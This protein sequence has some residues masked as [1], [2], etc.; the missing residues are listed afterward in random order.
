MRNMSFGKHQSFGAVEAN[1]LKWAKTNS[2]NQV[3]SVEFQLEKAKAQLT[4]PHKNVPF[5]F[6][7]AGAFLRGIT[8]AEGANWRQ[9]LVDFIDQYRLAFVG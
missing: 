3:E 5:T 4:G 6:Q 2:I 7:S 8:H 1:A 9:P